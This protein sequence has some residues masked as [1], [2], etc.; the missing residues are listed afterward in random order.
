MGEGAVGLIR[1]LPRRIAR[2][3]LAA[4]SAALACE[5]VYIYSPGVVANRRRANRFGMETA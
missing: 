2:I 4:E 1:G 3:W 5:P